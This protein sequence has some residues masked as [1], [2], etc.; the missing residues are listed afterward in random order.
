MRL[1][2]GDPSWRGAILAWWGRA[3]LYLRATEEIAEIMIASEDIE[4]LVMRE[5]LR[6]EIERL[7][8]ADGCE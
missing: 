8:I 4:A 3:W 6:G 5:E 2:R 7:R 1:L